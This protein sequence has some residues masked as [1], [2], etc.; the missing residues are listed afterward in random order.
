[1][2]L[3][4]F[5]VLV[6]IAASSGA[7]FKPGTWYEGLRKPAWTPPGWVFPLVWTILYVL[8]ATAGWLVWEAN[9]HGIALYFWAAQWVFN[10]AWSW[11]FFGLKRM[12][13]GFADICFLWL[14]ACG[15]ILAA[16]NLV[17]L[18][19][20]LFLPYLVWISIAGVLNLT[21]WRLNPEWQASQRA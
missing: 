19:S 12:D 11:L 4:V 15:F 8:I 3:V 7:V 13:W 5:L 10:T 6:F 2:T 20:W 9:S 17:P 16:W 18:A 1:M 21:V 14:S